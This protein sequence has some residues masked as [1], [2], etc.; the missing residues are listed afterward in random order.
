MSFRLM[1]YLIFSTAGDAGVRRGGSELIKRSM[2]SLTTYM[3]A[4]MTAPLISLR[5]IDSLPLRTPASPVVETYAL[6]PNRRIYLE[7]ADVRYFGACGK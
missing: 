2:P 1:P 4:L 3:A 6:I 7:V 5:S